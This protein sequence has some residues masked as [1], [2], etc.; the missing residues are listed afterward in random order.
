MSSRLRISHISAHFV[1]GHYDNTKGEWKDSRYPIV[2]SR[3][4]VDAVVACEPSILNEA[5][6]GYIGGTYL[7]HV[8]PALAPFTGYAGLEWHRKVN[9]STNFYVGYQATVMKISGVGYRQNVQLGAKFGEWGGRG[10]NVF[11]SYFSGFSI[12]GEYFDTKENYFGL[13]FLVEF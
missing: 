12:H 8:D 4:F 2:Y 10:L 1:D 11:A 5:L 13:G 7:F 6:R 3:E 9:T